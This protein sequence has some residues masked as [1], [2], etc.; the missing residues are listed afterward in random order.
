MTL[1]Q[2]EPPLSAWLTVHCP[3]KPCQWTRDYGFSTQGLNLAN[4]ALLEHVQRRHPRAWARHCLSTTR[5][6]IA[7]HMQEF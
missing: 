7:V 4:F 6:A 1:A 2:F 3:H 5:A